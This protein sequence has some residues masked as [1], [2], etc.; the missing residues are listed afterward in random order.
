MI[1]DDVVRNLRKEIESRADLLKNPLN[2]VAV[3][4]ELMNS[5]PRL[6]GSEKKMAL[7]QALSTIADGADG[8]AGTEDDVIPKPMMDTIKALIEGKLIHHVVNL[9]ADVSK[10][11][12]DLGQAVETAKEA[13][14]ACGGCFALLSSAKDKKYVK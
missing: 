2:I 14:D 7:I 10:G 8:I 1:I 6:S 11:R 5:Y 13:Q 3:G 12:F 9:I 4:M